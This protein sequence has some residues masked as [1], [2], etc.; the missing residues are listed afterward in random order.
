MTDQIR[1]TI[2]K[3]RAYWFSDGIA[4]LLIGTL[5]V[6][7]AL[8]MLIQLL[9]PPAIRGFASLGFPLVILFGSF[10]SRKLIMRFKERITYP[11]TGYIEYQKP[12]GF[13]I[14]FALIM[15]LVFGALIAWLITSADGSAIIDWM[16]IIQGFVVALIWVMI[17]Y[18]GGGITRLYGVALVSIMLGFIQKLIWKSEMLG[19]VF[20][21]S[22]LGLI[23]IIS[24]GL[25]LRSFLETNQIAEHT[26]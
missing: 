18:Q 9:A 11:R 5:F 15:G 23:L 13:R 25:T 4:E 6:I 24:G 22:F 16:P 21:F 10:M 14:P 7:A 17:A 20:F 8:F 19:S 26:E 3:T 12:S 2:Q 1:S